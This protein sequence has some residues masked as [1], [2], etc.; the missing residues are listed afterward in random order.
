MATGGRRGLFRKTHCEL[1]RPCRFQVGNE[2]MV[3]GRKPPCQDWHG[4]GSDQ[5]GCKDVP[6][7]EAGLGMEAVSFF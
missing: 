1:F 3:F 5:T 2:G 4:V 6:R 7:S